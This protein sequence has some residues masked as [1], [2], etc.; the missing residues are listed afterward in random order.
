M[1]DIRVMIQN[2]LTIGTAHQL[3]DKRFYDIVIKSYPNRI[4]KQVF[5]D[6]Y[7]TAG[8]A[9]INLDKVY[10]RYEDLYSFMIYLKQNEE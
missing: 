10:S 5:V 9:Q 4:E 2:W 3:D 7:N 1:E 6:A 8:N